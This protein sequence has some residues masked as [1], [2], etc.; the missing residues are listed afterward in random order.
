[1]GFSLQW[2]LLLWSTGSIV[3]EH[4]LVALRHMG[5]SYLP[6]SGIEPMSPAWQVDTL[7]LI[8]QGSPRLMMEPDELSTLG[9][10]GA[11]FISLY[12]RMVYKDQWRSY[13][14]SSLKFLSCMSVKYF[15]TNVSCLWI[16]DSWEEKEIYEAL[17]KVEHRLDLS[18]RNWLK[19]VY[20]WWL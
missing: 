11:I 9:E 14:F 15:P 13:K 5:S 4:G 17:E 20:N 8:H 10:S 2:L 12:T 1:M 6:G 3:M 7:P 18:V 19:P 16:R